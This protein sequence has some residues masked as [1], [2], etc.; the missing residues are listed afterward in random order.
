MSAKRLAVLSTHPIQYQSAWFQALAVQPGLDVH[1]YYCHR[2]TPL[3]QARAGFGVAFEW[4]IPLLA[5]Y[6]HSFLGNVAN[7]PGQGRFAGFDTPVIKDIIRRREYDAVLVNGWHYKSAWQAIWACWQSQVKVMVR[8]DSHLHASRSISKRVAKSFAYR[9]FIPR[10]DACLA[11]GQW[12]REYFLHY[13]ARAE[14]IFLVPHVVDNQRLADEYEKLRPRRSELRNMWGLNEACTTFLFVGKF[15]EGKKPMDFMQAI[16]LAVRAGAAV[17]GLMVGD[18]P[19]WRACEHFTHTN[20]TPVRFTGF[21][22]QSEIVQAY[23][24]ADVLVVPSASETWGL[25]TNEAMLC[26][27]PCIVS[28]QVGCAPDLITDGETGAVFQA[29]D[30][31][32]LSALMCDLARHR[33]RILA[34]GAQARERIQNYSVQAAVDGVLQSLAAVTDSSTCG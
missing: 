7:P 4:D 14:R 28:D 19:L 15:L 34:M 26:A 18:G 3:E 22:N 23:T 33:S 16:D 9:Y 12:S 5:G 10:I 2:A 11:V 20:R 32:G 17:D 30:V 1:V 29:G 21:L 24:A 27:R 8:G 13:G 6:P 31:K 25:V